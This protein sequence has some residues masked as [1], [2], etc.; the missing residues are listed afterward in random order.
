LNYNGRARI[1][2]GYS[3]FVDSP[4]DEQSTRGLRERILR[5]NNSLGTIEAEAIRQGLTA[6]TD[7]SLIGAT[8]E[9]GADLVARLEMKILPSEDL[10]SR[11][12]SCRL[13]LVKVNHER[14][15]LALLK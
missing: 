3:C 9:E 10:K 5:T 8:F 1:S 2:R 14:E 7:K 13:N 15:Q 6:F 4:P 11:E 12:I